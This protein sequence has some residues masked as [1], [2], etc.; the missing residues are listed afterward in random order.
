[1]IPKVKIFLLTHAREMDRKTN[2]GSLAVN[3]ADGMVERILWERLNPNQALLEMLERQEAVLMYPRKGSE[4]S[5]ELSSELSDIEAFENIVIIDGTWQEAQKIVNRSP[6][7]KAALKA[8]LKATRP[9][10]YKLRRNQPEGGLCTIECII[11]IFKIKG[12]NDLAS[13]LELT[14]EKFNG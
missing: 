8:E 13:K 4:Q 12:H 3:A 2:T 14:F 1:M 9:S 11:E 5:S 10:E 7:L 6:Y